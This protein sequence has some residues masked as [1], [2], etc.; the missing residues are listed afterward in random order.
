MPGQELG[1]GGSTQIMGLM[2]HSNTANRT[3]TFPDLTGT[4][5]LV[6]GSGSTALKTGVLGAAACE[7]TIT[8][9]ANGVTTSTRIQWNF[10]SDPSAIAG[11]G[12]VPVNAVHIYAWPTAGNVNFRQCSA[13]AVRPGAINILWNAYN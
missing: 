5:E 7:A 12:S 4:T 11:Y 6:I 1:I 3:Y 10:A 9:P 8:V 13:V 2:T